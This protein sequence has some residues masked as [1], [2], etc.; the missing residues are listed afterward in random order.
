M[1][2]YK[3]AA[4]WKSVVEILSGFL[5]KERLARFPTLPFKP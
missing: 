3:N 4:G 2:I 1:K 5:F